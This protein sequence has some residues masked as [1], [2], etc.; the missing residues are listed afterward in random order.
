MTDLSIQLF[1]KFSIRANGKRLEG[2]DSSK[3][4]QLFAYLLIYR[5]RSHPR[6]GLA[7]LLW[8][9]SSTS[10]SKKY[11]RQALWQLQQR[12]REH[13]ILIEDDW[14][15]ISPE[16]TYWLDVSEFEEA[17]T[18]AHGI[19]GERL[20]EKVAVSLERAAA[21][22]RGDLLEGWYSDWCLYERERLQNMWMAML[23]KLMGYCESG[24]DFEAGLSFGMQVLRDDRARERTHRRLMRM[25]YLAGDRTGAIRQYERCVQALH[26]ELSV[27]PSR[28]TE[29]LHHQ[30]IEDSFESINPA[31]TPKPL[32]VT[33]RLGQLRSILTQLREHVSE[34]LD[35]LDLALTESDE[36]SSGLQP[37]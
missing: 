13:L 17:F 5:D 12:L 15:R 28:R 1:G 10:Q 8:K 33:N 20:S 23:D 31:Y 18:E 4:Q 11:L 26:E 3:L 34:D 36:P 16:A 30:I 14:I 19:P 35:A 9:T 22:Y 25:A 37:H 7:D 21:L 6:E 32:L 24:G 27:R 2:I 29:E